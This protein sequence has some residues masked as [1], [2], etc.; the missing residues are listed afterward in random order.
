MNQPHAFNASDNEAQVFVVSSSSGIAWRV[1]QSLTLRAVIRHLALELGVESRAVKLRV[2]HPQLPRLL[3]LDDDNNM[4]LEDLPQFVELWAWDEAPSEAM[5]RVFARSQPL[6]ESLANLTHGWPLHMTVEPSDSTTFRMHV[7]TLT[8]HRISLIARPNTSI[9]QLKRQIHA[10]EMI[11]DNQKLLIFN[12]R[13]LQDADTLSQHGIAADATIH[14]VLL[15]RR[16][17]G[18]YLQGFRIPGANARNVSCSSELGFQIQ[19]KT[20]ALGVVSADDLDALQREMVDG[21]LNIQVQLMPQLCFG[22]NASNSIPSPHVWRSREF[23]T[24]LLV[25]QRVREECRGGAESSLAQIFAAP[26]WAEGGGGIFRMILDSLAIPP[27]Q[28]NVPVSK[29]AGRIAYR[30]ERLR[31]RESPRCFSC[32][33]PQPGQPVDIA[34]HGEAW[35]SRGVTWYLERRPSNGFQ[36]GSCA[37]RRYGVRWTTDSLDDDEQDPLR[38]VNVLFIPTAPLPAC[39]QLRIQATS[40]TRQAGSHG[41]L[42]NFDVAWHVR[43]AA[44][45]GLGSAAEPE[46]EPV[47]RLSM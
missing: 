46:S 31:S 29:V 4:P 28:W 33:P 47:V 42:G 15:R 24:L 43:T 19:L 7:Q 21:A 11:S 34:G 39:S 17:R 41:V 37:Q 1:P 26:G 2:T 22:I 6:E 3:P 40:R 27:S 23:W 30:M 9:R 13:Q 36:C 10:D 14:V 44:Q 32:G 25:R 16:G 12:G 38:T 35:V 20:L 5:L 45:V 8:G 18:D